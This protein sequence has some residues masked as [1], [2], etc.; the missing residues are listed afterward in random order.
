M[1]DSSR[2]TTD[3][4]EHFQGLILSLG[5]AAL[6]HLDTGREGGE[7]PLDL[8]RAKQGIGLLEVLQART[9]GNLTADEERLLESVLFD[10]RMRFLAAVQR[11]GAGPGAAAS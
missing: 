1:A 6:A 11:A 3:A 2:R 4:T 9:K 5:T 7:H 10:L 8:E